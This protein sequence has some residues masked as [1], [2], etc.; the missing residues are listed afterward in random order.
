MNDL[1]PEL[2]DKVILTAD[3][4]DRWRV[5]AGLIAIP[6][7]ARTLTMGKI[8]HWMEIC[9][10]DVNVR[11]DAYNVPYLVWTLNGLI[12]RNGDLPAIEHKNGDKEWRQYDLLHRNDD[13]PALVRLSKPRGRQSWYQ[14]GLLYRNEDSPVTIW[15][16][17][18]KVYSRKLHQDT[19]ESEHTTK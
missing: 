7:F 11:L 12:H 8:L 10:V 3:Q 9:G 1:L 6:R 4:C 18:K 17:G 13:K 5:Y 15:A 16:N 14:Y 19:T 2:Y